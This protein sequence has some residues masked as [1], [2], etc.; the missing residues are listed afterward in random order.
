MPLQLPITLTQEVKDQLLAMMKEK[1]P[2]PVDDA[3]LMD[4]I[5][6]HGSIVAEYVKT[7]GIR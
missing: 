6:T 1:L 5:D 4:I 2:T 7:L 3:I